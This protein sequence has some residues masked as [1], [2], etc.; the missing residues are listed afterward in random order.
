MTEESLS[1]DDSGADAAVDG[2]S[3]A[4]NS[5]EETPTDGTVLTDTDGPQGAP[6]EYADFVVPEGVEVDTA[7]LE[8]AQPIF[9]EIGLSQIQGQRLVDMFATHVQASTQ[10]NSDSYNQVVKDW[11]DEAKA[12]TEI[13]GTAFD[14]NVGIAKRGLDSFGTPKLVEVLNQ[15]GLGNHP[16]VIRLF[17]KI[18]KTLKEDDPGATGGATG[19]ELTGAQIMYP[20]LGKSA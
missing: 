7:L 3:E 13:G 14:E 1:P 12:D 15:T 17:T 4:D 6:E 19:E 2:N 10:A 11:V 8:Q 9:K 20:D 16:E 18:G 5:V